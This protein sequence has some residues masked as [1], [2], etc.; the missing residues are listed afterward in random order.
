MQQLFQD[1]MCLVTHFNKSD[2]FMTFTTN[3]KWEE[4]TAALFTDQTVVNKPDIIARVF[5][6]KLKDLINQ[7]RNGEIFGIVPA[8]I[9]TIKYQKRGLS[10]THI[11]IFLA[12]GHVFSEPETIDNLIRAELPNRALNPNRSLTEI[13]KQVIIHGL[14][15]SLKPNAIYMKKAHANASLTYSKQFPK[16][17]ANKT[18][19]NSDNY[20]KYRRRRTV[21]SINIQWG[22]EDIYDNR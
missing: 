9:Y 22:D 13:M 8:L 21:D 14:Y 15:G 16:P 1:S 3:P 11:I 10:H 18:I 6:A 5:R 2:L 17:F 20:P 19:V 4:V 7:I 12:G